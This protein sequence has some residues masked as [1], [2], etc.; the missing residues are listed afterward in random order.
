MPFVDIHIRTGT[1]D[2]LLSIFETLVTTKDALLL[3]AGVANESG[4]DLVLRGRL[5]DVLELAA[6]VRS[7]PDHRRCYYTY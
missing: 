1:W 4:A 6:S 3:S 7:W 5:L 2:L